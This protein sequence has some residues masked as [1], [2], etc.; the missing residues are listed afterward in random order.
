MKA[1]EKEN[2][3]GNGRKESKQEQQEPASYRYSGSPKSQCKN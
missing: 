2:K 1:K 3:V